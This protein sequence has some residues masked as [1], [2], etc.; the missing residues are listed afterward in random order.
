M[1]RKR[2]VADSPISRNLL[3]ILQKGSYKENLSKL[4]NAGIAREV[5]DSWINGKR[6][7]QM[8]SLKEVAGIL[9]FDIF[10]LYA[11]KSEL[12]PEQDE[13][14]EMARKVKD[15]KILHAAKTILSMG[16]VNPPPQDKFS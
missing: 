7:P 11:D 16:I 2:K 10:S 15:E 6:Q 5:V 12:L 13:V 14:C 9:G 8:A 1:G 4:K 3:A